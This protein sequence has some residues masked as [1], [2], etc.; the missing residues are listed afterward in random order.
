MKSYLKYFSQSP[1]CFCNF[2]LLIFCVTPFIL[3]G[4]LRFFIAS[5]A[6]LPYSQQQHS[7]T[8]IQFS[9]VSFIQI[10]I[11]AL[12]PFLIGVIFIHLSKLLHNSMLKR[13]THA[14][15]LFFHSNPLG[16]IINRFSK[17]TAMADSVITSQVMVWLQVSSTKSRC[18]SPL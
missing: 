12:T 14:P 6:A 4:Y 15:M 2:G 3:M 5:L 10:A 1:G 9:V 16:R 7:D 17:D 11:G 18:F 13:V 8:K